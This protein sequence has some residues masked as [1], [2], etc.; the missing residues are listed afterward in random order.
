[1]EYGQIFCRGGNIGDDFQGLA[2][3]HHL[4]EAPRHFIDRDRIHQFQSTTPTTVIMNGWFSANPEAWPPA[5]SINP[6]FVGFHIVDQIKPILKQHVDYLR[7]YEPIGTRDNASRDFLRSIGV[8]A[9]TTYCLTM[10]FRAREKMPAAGKVM[11]VDADGIAIP[12]P[13]R[14]GALKLTH[15]MPPLDYRVTLPCAEQLLELYRDTARL[16]ITTRLHAALPCIAMGI[17]V[18]YFSDPRDGRANIVRDI[19]GII[20]H[21]QLHTKTAA[22]GM[23]G[24]MIEH[25]DWSPQPLDISQFKARMAAAVRSRLHHLNP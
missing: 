2:A 11:I 19:G 1:M 14:A 13:L 3:R 5:P 20:Y 18:V 8:A 12:K 6:I 24:K 16:V 22:R 21:K 17:P 23:L 9:E 15:V 25:V 10:T 7:R 4:P